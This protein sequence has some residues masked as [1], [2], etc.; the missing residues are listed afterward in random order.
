[1]SP[2]GLVGEAAAAGALGGRTGAG[3]DGVTV[4]TLVARAWGPGAGTG[5]VWGQAGN[6]WCPPGVS[7]GPS[8]VQLL[9]QRP[10]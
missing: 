9:H 3:G 2:L 7:T 10:G 1:M 5:V 4:G 8:L 6:K